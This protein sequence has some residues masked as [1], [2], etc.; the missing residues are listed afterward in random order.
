MH[1]HVPTT[2]KGKRGKVQIEEALFF[3][4]ERSTALATQRDR[5]GYWIYCTHLDYVS[6][7]SLHFKTSEMGW[8]DGS[9]NK[10]L[11]GQV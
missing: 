11:V 7:L 2:H 6:I 4:G 10:M 1:T 9:V 5:R 8:E 3:L